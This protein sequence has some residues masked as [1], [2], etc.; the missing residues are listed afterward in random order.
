MCGGNGLTI[1]T[2]LIMALKQEASVN[3]D[4]GMNSSCTVEPEKVRFSQM[5]ISST[6]SC[7]PYDPVKDWADRKPYTNPIDLVIYKNGNLTSIDNRRLF[8]AQHARR[9]V[10]HYERIYREDDHL[11]EGGPLRFS[12][13]IWWEARN[14]NGDEGVYKAN[15][16]ASTFGQAIAFR[17]AS[18]GPDFPL[19]GSLQCPCIAPCKAEP[20]SWVRRARLQPQQLTSEPHWGVV[21]TT[22]LRCHSGTPLLVATTDGTRGHLREDFL[23]Y[24]LNLTEKLPF[25]EVLTFHPRMII[26][27]AAGIKALRAAA[28]PKNEDGDEYDRGL[29]EEYYLAAVADEEEYQNYEWHKAMGVLMDE[30]VVET[31]YANHFTPM[32]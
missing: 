9:E 26:Q 8:S 2:L 29:A 6:Y 12:V 31:R 10:I 15:L 18:Q 7:R 3:T 24:L 23:R 11:P 17:A 27:A 20:M 32:E 21:R 30:P 4:T 16:Q 5:Y 25:V 19:Y 28:E 1:F 22:L 14:D 13:S